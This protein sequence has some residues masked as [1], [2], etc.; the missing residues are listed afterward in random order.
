MPADLNVPDRAEVLAGLTR[1]P[2]MVCN[3]LLDHAVQVDVALLDQAF[4]MLP[5]HQPRDAEAAHELGIRRDS[6]RLACHLREGQ[7]DGGVF[8]NTA[9]K[10]DV[11][12]DRTIAHHPV[13]V[14]G[15]DGKDQAGDDVLACCALLHRFADVGV[16][17]RRAVFAEL[18][19]SICP[20]RD[21]TDLR[22]GVNVQVTRGRFL[23]ERTCPGRAGFVHRVVDGDAIVDEHVLGVLSADLEYRVDIFLEVRRTDGVRDDLVVDAD[24]LEENAQELA[25]RSRGRHKADPRLVISQLLL[26]LAQAKPECGNRVSVRAAIVL[27]DNLELLHIDERGLGRRGTTVNAKHILSIRIINSPTRWRIMHQST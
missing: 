16:D 18:Q 6:D 9:L 10:H 26:D 15:D 24:G 8:G 19:R 1:E 22:R 17:K 11:L 20:E 23:Q 5:E 2:F 3:F 7:R 27:R 21:R 13:S 12:T 4:F 25:R 14:V